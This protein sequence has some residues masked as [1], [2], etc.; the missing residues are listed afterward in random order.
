MPPWLEKVTRLADKKGLFTGDLSRLQDALLGVLVDHE[1]RLKREATSREFKLSLIS[2]G[3]SPKILF[4][5]LFEARTRDEIEEVLDS[6]GP[7]EYVSEVSP[8][9]AAADISALQKLLDQDAL[10]A[11]D[12]IDHG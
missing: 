9:E 7:V 12:L 10:G 3:V 11:E 1:Q 6:D 2:A 4:P 5:D 8:A